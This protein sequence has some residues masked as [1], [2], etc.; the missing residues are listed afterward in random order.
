M[1]LRDVRGAPAP[2][3][4]PTA[5]LMSFVRSLINSNY[6]SMQEA[7]ASVNP[8]RRR[9]SLI[10]ASAN[11]V[12]NPQ[13]TLMMTAPFVTPN[14][15]IDRIT[16]RRRLRRNRRSDWSRR[17]VREANVTVDDLIWPIFL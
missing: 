9:W 4:P 1:R 8:Q 3:G 14:P 15:D 6:G 11:C 10:R 7:L 5:L 16:G 17:L 13:R 12:R 2:S